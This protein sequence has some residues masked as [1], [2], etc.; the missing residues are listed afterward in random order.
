MKKL[1]LIHKPT[2]YK[3]IQSEI[4]IFWDGV[5]VVYIQY[6]LNFF[7]KKSNKKRY[8][9]KVF[10]WVSYNTTFTHFF[11]HNIYNNNTS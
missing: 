1:W 9:Y 5:N 10:W 2:T 3:I 11:F 6:L 7:S 8:I 4:M